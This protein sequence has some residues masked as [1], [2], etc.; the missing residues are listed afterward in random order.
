MGTKMNMFNVSI[1]IMTIYM[2][3]SSSVSS[4][5][6]SAK[7]WMAIA[8]LIFIAEMITWAIK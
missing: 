3:A 5:E 6:R 2:A 4:N 8:A 7:V 1:I